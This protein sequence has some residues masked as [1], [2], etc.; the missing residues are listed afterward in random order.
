MLQT[1]YF[2][3]CVNLLLLYTLIFM[4]HIFV[5]NIFAN[6]KFHCGSNP[7]YILIGNSFLKIYNP[8][9]MYAG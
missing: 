6:L 5:L 3:I 7:N 2:I 9:L 8:E 1:N 4:L